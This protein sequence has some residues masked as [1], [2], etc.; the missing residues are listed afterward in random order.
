[1]KRAPTHRES[2]QGMLEYIILVVLI[3]LIVLFAI[4]RFGRNV[5]SR[6]DC[7]RDTLGNITGGGSLVKPGC[8]GTVTAASAPQPEKPLPQ[9]PAVP[10]PPPKPPAPPPQVD[11]APP[12][13]AAPPKLLCTQPLAAGEFC[14]PNTGLI[15]VVVP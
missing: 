9:I 12:P 3:G 13:P 11:Q 5:F 7:A 2:G 8:D 4:S 6:Y 10:P 14:D 15:T 1:V